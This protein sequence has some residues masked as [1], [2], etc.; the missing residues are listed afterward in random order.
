[1]RIVAARPAHLGA[2]AGLMAASP[3]LRRYG[4]THRGARAS[5]DE[6]LRS[7]DIVVAALD[8]ATALGLAWMVPTRALDRSAYLRLLLVTEGRRSRGLGAAL[9]ADA[10]RRVRAA[11]AR[12]VV[13]LVTATNRRARSFY[14]GQGY[15]H[16]GVL[17]SFARP[18]ISEALYV[19]TWPSSLRPPARPKPRA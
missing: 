5:L 16:V 15:L 9:L 19:R 7:K 11:G 13:L 4:V 17:A 3:L 18:G 14:A 1:M 6:A 12:H 2:L 8:G 10:E